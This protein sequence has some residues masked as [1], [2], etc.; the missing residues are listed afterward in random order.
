MI[1]AQGAARAGM[2]AT[3]KHPWR[4]SAGPSNRHLKM[5]RLWAECH[6]I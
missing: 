2:F 6:L 4:D 5:L 3:S 1:D